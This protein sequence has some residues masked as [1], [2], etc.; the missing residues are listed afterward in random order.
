MHIG[1]SNKVECIQLVCN[2][3]L[4][5]KELNVTFQLA[6]FFDQV[7]VKGQ[8]YCNCHSSSY[9]HSYTKSRHY[10]CLN[11]LN[12]STLPIILFLCLP[13]L[14]DDMEYH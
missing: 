6:P 10:F 5:F 11:I 14:L 13:V 3:E 4:T 9:R 12:M 2:H 1:C 8:L 7:Y